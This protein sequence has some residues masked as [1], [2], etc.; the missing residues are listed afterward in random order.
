MSTVLLPLPAVAF[1]LG[2][3]APGA[4]AFIF[5]TNTTT[6]LTTYQDAQSLTP[7]SNPV[8]ADGDGK[9]PQIFYSGPTEARVVLRTS[10]NELI[11]VIDPAPRYSSTGS[12]ADQITFT[13]TNGNSATNV[14]K[15]IENVSQAYSDDVQAM[16]AADDDQALRAEIG[17]GN[18]DEARENLGLGDAATKV[19]ETT[20]TD[21]DESVPTSGAVIKR[22]TSQTIITQAAKF[23]GLTYNNGGLITRAHGLTGTAFFAQGVLVCTTTDS[24]FDIGDYYPLPTH[25]D[26]DTGATVWTDPTNIY[27]RIGANGIR[28]LDSS[29]LANT[30][31]TPG[32]WTLTLFVWGI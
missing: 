28:Y 14:Q 8:V 20:L 19:A 10:D 1:H 5:E 11:D 13:P 25:T 18:T 31:I 7:H 4:K 27:V 29:G 2:V 16:L 3:Y 26:A 21:N 32:N 15:A 17:L 9:F 22:I 6:P 12:S 30:A 23:E 24:P